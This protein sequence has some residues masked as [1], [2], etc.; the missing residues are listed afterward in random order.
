MMTLV[1]V[2]L[3]GRKRLITFCALG[4]LLFLTPS[5]QAG[6]A[7]DPG[8][9]VGFFMTVADRLLR[10]QMGLSV[11]N[12][13]VYTDNTFVYSPAVQRLLQLAANIYDSSTNRSFAGAATG[14]PFYPSVF[15]PIFANVSG[16]NVIITGFVEVTNNATDVLS[17]PLTLPGDA[18]RA[19][20]ATNIYG[21]PYIIG[22]RKGLPNFN[23]C[24]LSS[25]TQISRPVQV[26]KPYFSAPRN[27]WQTNVAY[28]IGISNA[29][30]VEA[31]NS[32]TSTYPRAVEI[33]ARFDVSMAL[34]ATNQPGQPRQVLATLNTNFTTMT[35]VPA[36]SWTGLPTNPSA[37]AALTL[38][39]F[40]VPL[41]TNF[42]LVS[43]S[44][45]HQDPPGLIPVTNVPDPNFW[46]QTTS[47]IPPQ[48]FL[49]ITNR[50]Q[51]VMR[52]Q[53]T[54]RIID[55]VQLAGPDTVEDL[56]L[57]T[58]IGDLLGLWSTNS[59]DS[60]N[61]KTITMGVNN[62]L[63][64]SSGTPALSKTLWSN[65]SLDAYPT[66]TDSA[67]SAFN[68]FISGGPSNTN[69]VMQAPFTPTSKTSVY[70]RLQANDPLVHY[71]AADLALFPATNQLTR[72]IPSA[73]RI[74]DLLPNISRINDHYQPWGGNPI[75][76]SVNDTN[77]YNLAVKDPLVR[78]SDDW[79]FPLG[80]PIDL[81]WLG[82]VHRGT[83]WQTIYLKSTPVSLASWQNYTGY[84]NPVDA[85]LSSPTND[86]AIVSA[87][88][89]LF[90]TNSPRNPLSINHL[91]VQAFAAVFPSG[92]TVL[93]N[94]TSN[95]FYFASNSPP[96]TPLRMDANSV[97]TTNILN[98]LESLRNTRD[99]SAF[100]QVGEVLA[101]PELSV[102]SPWLWLTPSQQQTGI[103]DAAYEAIPS[104]LIGFLRPD[105][106]GSAQQ[107]GNSIR[108][109]FT[110]FDAYPYQIQASHDL[111]N[112]LSVTNG[113]PANGTI[114]FLE[115]IDPGGAQTYFRAVLQPGPP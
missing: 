61:S 34:W 16:N 11:T 101:L 75:S 31:W 9:P 65:N 13:P 3:R 78:R 7:L 53:E 6:S 62:Q 83:P 114:D 64:F 102:N 63:G 46:E 59:L 55:Y 80:L 35:T 37:Q 111:R 2:F 27:L 108:L 86:W 97:Q 24:S 92:I 89:P 45:Y 1:S 73:N 42:A 44:F 105:P 87:L 103:K 110:G 109:S 38:A 91:D 14:D 21:V 33:T 22:A 28:V 56:S 48:F 39:T 94:D 41:A 5:G 36:N 57:D 26:V 4:V 19:I 15:R 71:L 72:V 43:D 106:F 81:N 90:D 18:Y 76:I 23:E 68:A 20:E 107:V 58:L 50:L 88:A 69:V 10:T 54:G 82:R 85:G 112:W 49:G 115:T 60:T 100:R 77:K 104:Q 66:G 47:F 84:G 74:T 79:D 95:P 70:S 25:F 29:V 51:F 98:A 32:Y 17:L 99:Q 93:T 96:M 12:I 8:D 67:I 40:R 30:G 52:D 113:T